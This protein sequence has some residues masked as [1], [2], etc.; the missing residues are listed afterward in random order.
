MPDLYL[1]VGTTD[2]LHRLASD[3]ARQDWAPAG[4]A[5]LDSE[6]TSVY[7]DRASGR[8]L[9]AMRDAERGARI[10]L[11]DDRGETW[12]E[13]RRIPRFSAGSA[14][15]VKQVWTIANG[16]RPGERFAGVEDAGLFRSGDDGE[17]W[18]EVAGLRAFLLGGNPNA[19]PASDSLVHSVVVAPDE[20]RRLW[21]A[22]STAGVLRSDDGG[23]LTYA[24]SVG[25]PLTVKHEAAQKP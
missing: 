16:A 13:T 20:P 8:V 10:W 3:V 12:R 6:I 18:E 5:F 19:T 1:F 24:G 11:S 7:A 17:S 2:G 4:S 15:A 9:V 14:S 23:E 22:T 25:T 21:V